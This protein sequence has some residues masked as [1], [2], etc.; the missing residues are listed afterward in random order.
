[1]SSKT[2][3]KFFKIAIVQPQFKTF[4]ILSI[5]IQNTIATN[6]GKDL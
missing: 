6:I 3:K 5:Q 2:Y 1:M 4:Q